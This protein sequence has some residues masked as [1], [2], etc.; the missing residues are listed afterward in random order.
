MPFGKIIACLFMASALVLL[1]EALN[2]K[3]EE[4]PSWYKEKDIKSQFWFYFGFKVVIL[5][6]ALLF[7]LYMG[8][9]IS[10]Q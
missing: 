2:S 7:A 1:L 6:V 10:T 3:T 5:T 4:F 9:Q 8:I